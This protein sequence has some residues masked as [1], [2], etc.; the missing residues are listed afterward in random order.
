[1]SPASSPAL[2][3]ALFLDPSH[4]PDLCLDCLCLVHFCVWQSQI[5]DTAPVAAHC[6]PARHLHQQSGG[7]GGGDGVGGGH[8]GGHG[9]DHGGDHDGHDV[10]RSCLDDAQSGHDSD[11]SGHDGDHGLDDDR[12]GGVHGEHGGDDGDSC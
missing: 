1:M 11:P 12:G 8:G 7:C 5:S 2:S 4:D 9:G 6:P 3:P 10:D